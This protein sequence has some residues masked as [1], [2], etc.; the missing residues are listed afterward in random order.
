MIITEKAVF[1]VDKDD[2]L[3]LEEMWPGVGIPDIQVSTGCQ[4]KIS[5]DLIEM[6]QIE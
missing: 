4:F 2:G 6:Q 5:N 3:V 1:R